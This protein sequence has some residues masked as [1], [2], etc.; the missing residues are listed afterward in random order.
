MS[1]FGLKRGPRHPSVQ[2]CRSRGQSGPAIDELRVSMFSNFPFQQRGAT[3]VVHN[4][5]FS[6]LVVFS[7]WDWFRP[8]LAGLCHG[9]EE[10][11]GQPHVN[12]IVIL[13]SLVLQQ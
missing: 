7:D 1:A 9:S 5:K 2:S 6:A 4:G 13:K 11:D 8:L 12:V 10:T 3:L